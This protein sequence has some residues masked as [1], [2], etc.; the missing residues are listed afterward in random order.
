MRLLTLCACPHCA[1]VQGKLEGKEPFKAYRALEQLGARVQWGSP[2][3]PR[4]LPAG[5]FD[6]RPAGGCAR[7]PARLPAA[8]CSLFAVNCSHAGGLRQ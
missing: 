3:D 1:W 8:P 5:D 4:A 2:T 6:V 7:R